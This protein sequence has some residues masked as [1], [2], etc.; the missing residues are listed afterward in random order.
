MARGEKE[1]PPV[2][3][4]RPPPWL[5]RAHTSAD[6]G[7]VGFF[8]PRPDQEEEV[9]T[10]SN[11]KNGLSQ[12]QLVPLETYSA[13]E[14]VRTRLVSENALAELEDLMDQI[15]ARKAA[16]GPTIQA[17]TFRLPSRVT[18]NDAKRLAWFADLANPD[19]PLQKLGKSVPHGA[20]GHDLLDLLHGNNVAI[21][22]AV[23]FL[24]VFGGNETVGLR[25]KPQY[26]PTQYSVDWAN[27]VT[28]YLRKQLT[29]IA[30]PMAPRPGL[31]IK[32][33]FKGVLS[34]PDSRG[35]WLSRF[36]Y[37]L[38]LLRAFYAE[39]L[40]D[41]LTFLIWL[42]Q[43]MMTCNLAQ[44]GFVARI[45]DEYLDGVLSCRALSRPLVESCLSRL[46]EIQSTPGREHLSSLEQILKNMLLRTL[47]ALPDSYVNPRSWVSH[48][49]L[50][51]ATLEEHLN[52]ADSPRSSERH[53]Q[54]LD[55]TLLDTLEDVKNRN[56][57]MLF[58]NL[59]PRVVGLLSSALSDIKLLNSLS[60]KSDLRSI[61]FFDAGS[62]DKAS[63]PRKLD[64][65]LTWSITPLQYGDHRPYAAV[66]LLRF[67]RDKAEERAIRRWRDS[68]DDFIQD[69]LF[70]W[71]D[72]S[73]VAADLTNLSSI[74]LVFGQLVKQGLFSYP[75]YIQ[76]LI[77]RGEQGLDGNQD[78]KSPHRSFLQWIPLHNSSSALIGQ[79]KVTLYG[80]RARET[81][82]DVNERAIRQRIRELLPELF[83]GVSTSI[84]LN[85]DVLAGCE[86]VFSATRFEQVRVMH[87]WLLPVLKRFIATQ[88]SSF[89]VDD[90]AL[91]VYCIATTLLA[92]CR[93]YGTMLELTL[94]TLE[95]ATSNELLTAVLRT[96]RQHVE[97]WACFS[98]MQEITNTLYSVHTVCK[99]RGVQ[100]RPLMNLLIELDDGRLLNPA[101][102]EQ[103]LSDFAAFVHAL[104]PII[105]NPEPVP[106][107]LPEILLLATDPSTEAP[108]TL[109]NSLWYK[110][111]SS[112]DW[113]WKVW[114]N[115]VA[116]LR[117][118]PSMIE[119][120]PGRRACGCRYAVFLT[121]VDQ[122][123]PA[124]F[125]E[126]I[127]VWF[128]GSGRNEVIALS[129]E[130]W[131]VFT[132]VLLYLAIHGA[133]ATTT[134][135]TG[136]IY[137]IWVMA[138]ASSTPEQAASL[139]VLLNAAN[140]LC[141]HL[142]L[143]DVCID[144]IPPSDYYEVQGLQTR[145]RDVFRHPHFVALAEHTPT[146]VLIEHNTNL[147]VHLREASRSLR[148]SLCALSVFRL[149]I[150][151]DLETV[152]HAFDRVLRN[153]DIAEENHEHLI[154]ALRVMFSE[155]Q[156]AS[157][158]SI[159]EWQILST[160]LTPWKLAAT[161]IELRF[162]IQQLEEALARD[163]SRD[164]AR[165]VLTRLTSSLFKQGMSSEE[166]DFVAEMVKGA[167]VEVVSRFVNAGLRR[168]SEILKEYP[169]PRD[170]SHYVE[171]A[172]QAGEVLRFLT[173][174]ADPLREDPATNGQSF[175]LD[176]AAQEELVSELQSEFSGILDIL[177][178]IRAGEL[179]GLEWQAAARAL[180][181]FARILH[182][183]LGIP[184]LWTSRSRLDSET[185]CKTI[186]ELILY[187]GSG[188]TLDTIIFPLLI[189]T[190]YYLLDEIPVDPKATTYDPS[191]CYPMLEMQQ[192]PPDM[193]SPYRSRIRTL[194]PFVPP[195]NA[196]ADLAYVSKDGDTVMTPVQ[197]RPW[198]WT[199]YLGER[200]SVDHKD[201]QVGED[202]IKNSGSLSLD[203]FGAIP[204]GKWHPTLSS[205]GDTASQNIQGAIRMLQETHFT[206]SVFKRDWRESRTSVAFS[207]RA[208]TTVHAEAEDELSALP[209][210]TP[211]D[212]PSNSSRMASPVSSVRSRGSVQPTGSLRHQSP[213]QLQSQ[214]MSMSGSTVS[215]AI[216]V[217][218]LDV[219]M[220]AST[221]SLSQG[222]GSVK[223]KAAAD[224]GEGDEI[225]FV[226]GPV[227]NTQKKQKGKV[228]AGKQRAKKR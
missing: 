122:H 5:P 11:V 75:Q 133:L 88:G 190:L 69:Q 125:D 104:H 44:L 9:L 179:E 10:E 138:A 143:Q 214:R 60:G 78:H 217:D 136:L 199:E 81:P 112:S 152:H 96:L 198:E 110:Y 63:F 144:G 139:E 77:A 183:S 174:I 184:S 91:K 127:L 218:S 182:F 160:S 147:P 197:N 165:Q 205:R 135:L 223:R 193:P 168:T 212:R 4:C 185:I 192:L 100:S 53:T 156:N 37:S 30:L 142:L 204:V 42:L 49:A 219:D 14:P 148:E 113:A 137:P 202:S 32:Q 163:A 105:E 151:R 211:I 172:S 189:D 221:A 210:F 141:E 67:W 76:R 86:G 155:D 129:A 95:H 213:F 164:K 20:K 66:S 123:L 59:P 38:S 206:E 169:R 62:D 58:R 83:G 201:D 70:A 2:Y 149:G 56:E 52:Q 74:A 90:P 153:H 34:D 180:I 195:N 46:L 16:D 93:C 108:S 225:E 23:W 188:P 85:S 65:L 73:D 3:E 103:V 79:R 72:S 186:T 28:G 146:L 227:A 228:V 80:A 40:V 43:Q 194:L 130:A 99:S 18:L 106:A 92:R 24:R 159:E 98:R 171:I 7:Y 170:E 121:H 207:A 145:R 101:A 128:L 36:T 224:I 33:T 109:A 35:R 126:Q 222:Q 117:Q 226:E 191:S 161:S 51:E 187:T 158:L 21:P 45:A 50:L 124:G 27:L 13:Q 131:D 209:Q 216:D 97:V 196:V 15:L 19:V 173:N 61:S 47:L 215:D 181:L 116:S 1:P 208:A 48:A 87:G 84:N 22:R 134:I 167:S 41:N 55:R 6:L 150:Y 25:N 118:I 102:R 154:N 54:A 119:D 8:P 176:T 68:P 89:D 57:A 220:P 203:L 175:P 39:G 31:N 17:S 140:K 162:T 12:T 132:V 94:F 120:I 111:R 166:V 29:E 26:N 64:I 115:T 82:E 71:L 178:A 177:S 200:S 114:D 107:A 157:N